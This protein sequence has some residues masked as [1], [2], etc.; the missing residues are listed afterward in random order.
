MKNVMYQTVKNEIQLYRYDIFYKIF[1]LS[2]TPLNTNNT[3]YQKFDVIYILII[4]N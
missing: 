3:N 2:N 1:I 4:T